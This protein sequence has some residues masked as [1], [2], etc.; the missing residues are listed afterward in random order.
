MPMRMVRQLLLVM[1]LTLLAACAE[2]VQVSWT[3][4]FSDES[5]GW[6][7]QSDASAEVGHADG[8]M[9]VLVK[10]PNS[11]AW[12]S[13]GRDYADFQLAVDAAQV[14][15]PHDNEYGVQVRMKDNRHFYRFS[16]SGDGYYR[17]VKL[18]GDEQIVLGSDWAYS[19]AIHKGVAVNRLDVACRGAT[20][21]FRVN[22][23]LLAQV[24]DS[25]YREGDIG[26]YAGSFFEPD[27]EIRFDNLALTSP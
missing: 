22:D 11:F 2:E 12:A 7:A 20:M 19:E 13:A 27:V 15:G 21:T 17:V 6:Q 9:R 1:T 24:G 26:L 23:V 10:W 14:A 5:A 8:E 25:S 3:D 4:D 16:I 18:D